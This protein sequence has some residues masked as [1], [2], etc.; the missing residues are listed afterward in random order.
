MSAMTRTPASNTDLR[1]WR[2]TASR[3]DVELQAHQLRERLRAPQTVLLDNAC[4]AGVLPSLLDA[5][6]QSLANGWLPPTSTVLVLDTMANPQRRS[7]VAR[8][9]QRI[10]A[11]DRHVGQG[12]HA[13]VLHDSGSDAERAALYRASNVYLALSATQC[14][15]DAPSEYVSCRVAGYG[16]ILAT[17]QVAEICRLDGAVIADDSDATSLAVALGAVV[18]LTHDECTER[19]ARLRTAVSRHD[20]DALAGA[21]DVDTAQEPS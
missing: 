17:A 19:M 1:H 20:P 8:M 2:A 21:T 5:F 15:D 6:E 10:A 12:K 16:S 14:C 4:D 13:V 3:A 9:S 11:L 7:V 18:A